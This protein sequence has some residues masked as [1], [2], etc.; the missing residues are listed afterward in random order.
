MAAFAVGNGA[1]D[2]HA[3]IQWSEGNPVNGVMQSRL[4]R[5]IFGKP[6]RP[7]TFDRSWLTPAV[8]ALAQTIYD[9]RAFD[10]TPI[11]ADELEKA[12][13][14][15]QELLNHCRGPAPH[16]RGCWALDLVLGK[17]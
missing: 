3:H 14:D 15:S 10:Q 17:E 12:G 16:V 5:D 8:K 6:F 9:D 2:I 7:S 1:R 4:L 11:L 13:C